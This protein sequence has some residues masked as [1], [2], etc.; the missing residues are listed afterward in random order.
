MLIS[1]TMHSVLSLS[2]AYQL[3]QPETL[4]E[5]MCRDYVLCTQKNSHSTLVW[6]SNNILISSRCVP[7]LS[8]MI[9]VFW[10]RNFHLSW[11]TKYLTLIWCVSSIDQITILHADM[12]ETG[13]WLIKNQCF[14]W[15]YDRLWLH[16]YT[17]H[18][19]HADDTTFLN[20]QLSL[21]YIKLYYNT[22][23]V[24]LILIP[25]HHIDIFQTFE[26]YIPSSHWCIIQS[27]EDN[28][29]TIET[30]FNKITQ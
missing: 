19:P 17:M 2:L 7:M 30:Y 5:L 9:T 24:S 21:W 25:M 29:S 28:K 8:D 18:T 27:H 3:K 13:I 23:A 4:L 12:I 6:S 22:Q 11:S 16:P 20:I 1:I 14:D 15:I 26:G 10:L